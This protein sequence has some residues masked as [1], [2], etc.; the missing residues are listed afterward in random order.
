MNIE[1]KMQKFRETHFKD[2]PMAQPKDVQAVVDRLT[3]INPELCKLSDNYFEGKIVADL[4]P[5]IENKLCF[6]TK[7][8][9]DRALIEQENEK[10]MLIKLYTKFSSITETQEEKKELLGSDY[11][12]ESENEDDYKQALN[13]DELK[14]IEKYKIN[15]LGVLKDQTTVN[16]TRDRLIAKFPKFNIKKYF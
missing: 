6:I 13:A 11:V 3:E 2:K 8:I 10:N 15:L 7:D 1:R 5:F 4:L 12:S 14:L 9:I 16:K